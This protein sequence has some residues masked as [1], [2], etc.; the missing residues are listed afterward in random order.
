[1]A[2]V[3]DPEEQ[4]T[5]ALLQMVPSLNGARVLEIGSGYGRLTARYWPR[6]QSV[7]AIDP[8]PEA[9][10]ELA[11]NL[12]HVSAIAAG[13]EEFTL[14]DRSVDVVLFAWSL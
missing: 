6:A 10:D 2:I 4:E 12:P 9:V 1:L 14:P 11:Q 8:D 13:I 3:E 7:I 5:A